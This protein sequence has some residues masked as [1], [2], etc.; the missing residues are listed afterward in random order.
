MTIPPVDLRQH[1]RQTKKR[2]IGAGLV[3]IFAVGTGLIAL[4]YGTPAAGCGLAFFLAAMVP[5]GLVVLVL[6]ILQWLANRINHGDSH[7]G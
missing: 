4:T 5:V 3:L 6:Y 7:N 1:A 2:L